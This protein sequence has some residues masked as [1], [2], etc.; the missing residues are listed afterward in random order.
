MRALKYIMIFLLPCFV[1]CNNYEIQP[2]QAEGFIKFF[3]SSLGEEGVDVKPTSDGGYVAVGNSIDESTGLSDIYLVKTDQYGN[4]ESWSP[5]I[6]G[7]DQDDVVTAGR[8]DRIA[9]LTPLHIDHFIDEQGWQLVR[10]P[11]SQIAPFESLL[12]IRLG[13]G[14]ATEVPAP[15]QFL[16]QRFRFPAGPVEFLG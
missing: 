4:E 16:H 12:S 8:V 14:H 6:I 9:Y 15:A 7:G 10:G 5:V 3:S 13:Q 1:A 2:E 11:P